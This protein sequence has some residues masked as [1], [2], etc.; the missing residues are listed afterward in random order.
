MK[1]LAGAGMRVERFSSP[2]ALELS[3]L[4]ETT[5]LGL[6][7]AWAQEV[8]RYAREFEADYCEI[9]RFTEEIDYFPP[10]I[11][12]PGFIGG[13]CVMPNIDLLQTVHSSPLVQAIKRSNAWKKD[14]WRN[15]GR[16]LGERLAPIQGKQD[17]GFSG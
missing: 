4:L 6:L 15:L 17:K 3:K 14:E 2:E 8:E 12:Q 10:V 5:Y 11:F 1:H 9:M 13:H 16:P 7:I